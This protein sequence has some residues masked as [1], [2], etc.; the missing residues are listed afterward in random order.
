MI[1][2]AESRTAE[3]KKFRRFTNLRTASDEAKTWRSIIISGDQQGG[4]WLVEDFHK[5]SFPNHRSCQLKNSLGAAFVL[6]HN[7]RLFLKANGNL[8][9]N[10]TNHNKTA[11]ERADT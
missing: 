4:Q 8:G 5:V 11:R 3:A 10:N 6:M 9:Q 7:E 2:I 1:L